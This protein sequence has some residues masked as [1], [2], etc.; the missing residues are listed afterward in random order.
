[1]AA[2]SNQARVSADRARSRVRFVAGIALI[3]LA[4]VGLLRWTEGRRAL[5]AS[6]PPQSGTLVVAGV[7]A[8]VAIVRDRRGV[9]H[10]RAA[11]ERD[12]WFA[13]GF[14]HAQDRLAQMLWLRR[15]AAG[16]TAEVIG[17]AGLAAD[18]RARTLDLAGLARRD[19][20]RQGP[21]VRRVLDA[22]AAGVNARLARIRAREEGAPLALLEAVSDA[23][24]WTP[25]DSLA[26]VKLMAWSY[27]SGIDEAIVLEQLVRRLGAAAARPFFPRGVGSGAVP[28]E[29]EP[30]VDETPDPPAPAS[31]RAERVRADAGDVAA[32]RRAAGWA[33]ASIGSSAWVVAGAL[34]ARGRPLLAADAHL[35][36]LFPSH[37]YQADLAGGELQAAGATLPGVPVFWTG[38]NPW[39]TWAST[40]S[41]AVVADLFEETLHAE[42][43]LRYADGN[44]WRELSV[45]EEEIRS[46][47]GG[48]GERLRVRSTIRGPLV[49]ELIP[50]ADRPLSL[51]WTGALAGGGIEGLLRA[52]K[53]R[54]AE[55]L[56]A[57]LALHHEPALVV[58][59]ADAAGEAGVQLSGA[60][61][62]RRMASGLQPVPARNPAFAWSDTIDPAALP[63]RRMPPGVGWA[64]AADRSLAGRESGIEF[65]WQPGDRARRI[66]A[67]LAE[68][69]AAG[70]LRPA[71]L[72]AMLADRRAAAAEPLLTLVLAQATRFDA[73]SR[74]EREVIELLE[75]WDRDAGRRSAG[76]AVFHVLVAQL[77][78]ELYE[79]ALG[80]ELLERFLALPRVDGASLVLSALAAA[81]RGGDDE[82]PWTSRPFVRKALRESLRG[83][84]I[85]LSVELGTN[86]ER[87]AWGRLKTLRFAP[88]WPDAWRGDPARL[89]PFPYG[90]D[91]ASIAV[92]EHPALGPWAPRVIS[93]WRFVAD[94]ADLDQALTALA[95]GQSEHAGH[96]NATDGIERWIDDGLAL[97]STSDPVI[98]DGPVQRLVLVPRE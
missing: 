3:F 96:P 73:V 71:T 15:V 83:A 4:V 16:R 9:P 98:E 43:G 91:P 22:Y 26:L 84:W 85:S 1:V 23:D 94:T 60:L 52:A 54:S 28:P 17:D 41:S 70:P 18:R 78:R 63:R 75:D 40:G 67:L 55:Q 33:G 61:P 27:G 77:L 30:A 24:P 92:A 86:R 64:V 89:G 79:P 13:L 5:R 74:E 21:T 37:F 12:A 68:A 56:L 20:A 42:D 66:E 44:G 62:R 72:G 34:T 88:L 11:N 57:A 29:P 47:P 93:S 10:V 69:S 31:A 65:F 38:F 19:A 14:A 58:A 36:P 49:D 90:G 35:Q 97:L 50:G 45:R 39:L 82:L 8:P 53:A 51:R 32:L 87:W 95:P 76:A 80:R 46:S 48:E 59:Y 25:A 7:E 6:H 81:E 2:A